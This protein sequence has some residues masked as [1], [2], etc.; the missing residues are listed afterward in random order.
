M[1]QIVDLVSLAGSTTLDG[2]LRSKSKAQLLETLARRPV[3]VDIDVAATQSGQAQAERSA[4]ANI[5]QG[6]LENVRVRLQLVSSNTFFSDTTPDAEDL[7]LVSSG[8]T[9]VE[10]LELLL[11]LCCWQP[12]GGECTTEA[13]GDE[14]FLYDLAAVVLDS[15][16]QNSCRQRLCAAIATLVLFDEG[17]WTTKSLSLIHI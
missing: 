10:S 13:V 7:S 14:T 9:I 15:S 1:R 8:L 3:L 12:F 6:L 17:T 11:L 16:P 2:Q 5:V 4:L